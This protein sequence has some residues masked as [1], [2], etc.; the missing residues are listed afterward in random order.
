[1]SDLVATN[2]GSGCGCERCERSGSGCN[3]IIWILLILC[4]C[5]GNNGC[6]FSSVFGGN[7]DNDCCSI[8]WILLLLS[9]CG[10]NGG[11]FGGCGC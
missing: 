8:I 3:N 10:G 7:G 5:G 2:C 11:C 6:G 9:C 1:M 4:F